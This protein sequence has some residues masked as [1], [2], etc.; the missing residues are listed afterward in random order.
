MSVY[1]SYKKKLLTSEKGKTSIQVYNEK[2]LTAVL[3]DV[4]EEKGNCLDYDYVITTWLSTYRS[5]G[6]L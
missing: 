3:N 4:N 6:L 1:E 5:K 2:S